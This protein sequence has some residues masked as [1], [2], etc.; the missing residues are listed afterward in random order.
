MVARPLTFLTKKDAFNWT[1]E[2]DEAFFTLKKAL[3]EALILALLMFDKGF[4]AETNA[5][6]SYIGMQDRHPLAYI[7]SGCLSY[8]SL[9]MNYNTKKAR[10]I[11][12]SMLY[13]ARNDLKH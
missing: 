8:L 13:L 10:K 4:V 7:S 2:A 3:C 9:I 5:C 12:F 11:L 1:K 6:G